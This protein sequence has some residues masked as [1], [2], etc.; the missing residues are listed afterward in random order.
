M[1]SQSITD[2]FKA[3]GIN[4]PPCNEISTAPVVEK[5]RPTAPA[6]AEK[7]STAPAVVEKSHTAPAVES[8]AAPFAPVDP[9]LIDAVEKN[10][11]AINR[12]QGVQAKT[13]SAIEALKEKVE[14]LQK[15]NDDLTKVILSLM[16]QLLT[17][18]GKVDTVPAVAE[19]E[20][21]PKPSPLL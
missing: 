4:M 13:F 6:V 18:Q 15:Q 10:T 14:A 17:K 20:S 7:R 8:V 19:P 9:S 11:K 16:S 1:S 3:F 12:F 2:A 21:V 5:K